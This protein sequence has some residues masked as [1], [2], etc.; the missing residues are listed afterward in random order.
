MISLQTII[1]NI[2]AIIINLFSNMRKVN[3]IQKDFTRNKVNE[4]TTEEF[5]EMFGLKKKKPLITEA[6]FTKIFPRGDVSLVKALNKLL[7]KNY[8]D[9]LPRVSSFM[10]QCGH[11]SAGFRVF[12]ENLNY[13]KSALLRVF[14]KY[15]NEETATEYARKPEK[16]A[17]RV[18]ANRMSNG[19]EESGDG[20][21]YRGRGLIQ[22]TGKYNYS[23]FADYCAISLSD[24]VDYCET[25]NGMV[26]SAI[27]Y[28]N[29]HNCNEFADNL[30]IKG[31]TKVING[32][33]NGLAHREKLF[34]QCMDILKTNFDN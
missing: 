8:I 2:I 9:T 16:I 12:S 26:D 20:W 25:P 6:Q 21:K 3:K 17:N 30:D 34:K 23:V 32:G 31:Q 14:G 33:F 22:L 11:E 28:W 15:F 10:A 5:E 13:S 1:S 7:P 4:D 18:Y 27:W 19:P 29:A 24:A